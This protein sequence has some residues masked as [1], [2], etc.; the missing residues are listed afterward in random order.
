[1]AAIVGGWALAQEPTL[2]PGL[3][4]HAAAAT[5]DTLVAVVI[6]VVAGGMIVFPSI[7]LLFRLTLVGTLRG[8][9]AARPPA[10]LAPRELLAASAQGLLV[11]A[12]LACLVAGFGL[13][14]VLDPGWAH[15]LG[16]LALLGFVVLGFL[17][18]LPRDLVRPGGD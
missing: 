12:A 7:A 4:I 6:A 10:P 8:P 14:N 2:L 3:T 15:A 11:R 1:V 9:A 16:V 5:H 13:L 17:A 18:A